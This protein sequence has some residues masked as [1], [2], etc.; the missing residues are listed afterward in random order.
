MKAVAESAYSER[1]T[2]RPAAR[3]GWLAAATATFGLI[4]L[5]SLAA[6]PATLDT[7]AIDLRHR[8]VA[9]TAPGERPPANSGA[10][11]PR[12]GVNTFLEQEVEP[13]KRQR[14]L[15]L[16][17]AA[18][19]AW[20]RQELP[21]EQVEPEARGQQDWTK[22]DDIVDRA[23]AENIDLLLRLDTSPRW[24]L[25][26]N[27]P[28]GLSPPLRVEDYWDFVEQVATRYRGRVR[29]YQIWNEP[30][31][32]NEWGRQPPN[33][34]EYVRLLQGATQRIRRADPD[35][36]VVMAALAPTLTQSAEAENE[37]LYLQQVYDAGARGGVD[38]DVLAVQAYG[39]RGGPD[40]PR[41]GDNDVTFSRPELVRQVMQ[42]NGD[43]APVWAT[44][45]GWNVNPPEFAEQRFGRVTPTLQARYTL[46][47]FT[48]VGQQWPWMQALFVWYWKRAD[49]SNRGED[50][51]W[52]RLADA[53]FALQPVYYALRDGNLLASPSL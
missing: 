14:S 43:T 10:A 1:V 42:R 9:L 21:W 27:A 6:G 25:P 50:W 39:L 29:A 35:A 7:A 3:A 31:L 22:F 15:E 37:L 44:E 28:D 4:A 33:A 17:K 20:I 51:Y 11:A 46:R 38:Y 16:L 32:T 30:N 34:A 49:D 48:R 13:G 52:F 2:P 45:V 41:V 5:L 19:V 8:W 47:A 18:G 24:A 53:D 40:D 12:V 23:R 26:P 36:L